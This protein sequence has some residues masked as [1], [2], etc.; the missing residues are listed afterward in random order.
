MSKIIIG[1]IA[2]ILASC[3]STFYYKAKKDKNGNVYY[4]FKTDN[5]I[6]I[7]ANIDGF[8][9]RYED[10]SQAQNVTISSDNES[11]Q[12]MLPPPYKHPTITFTKKNYNDIQIKLNRV[13][14]KQALAL[15][16]LMAVPTVGLSLILDL[17]KPSFYKLDPQFDTLSLDFKYSDSYMLSEYNKTIGIDDTEI[18][19]KYIQSYPY[20]KQIRLVVNHR[21]SILVWNA[22]ENRS[23]QA[24]DEFLGL[25]K[26]NSKFASLAEDERNKLKESRE[27]FEVISRSE[28][29]A[30]FFRFMN[31][32]SESLEFPIAKKLYYQTTV[33]SVCALNQIETYWNYLEGNH[34]TLSTIPAR[35]KDRSEWSLYSIS[36]LSD[37]ILAQVHH[38]YNARL[39]LT[40]GQTEL[41]SLK[42][43]I[44]VKL[45]S[46]C[47]ESG[48]KSTNFKK[49]FRDLLEASSNKLSNEILKEIKL[50]E[51]VD[52]A[53]AKKFHTD[54]YKNLDR[55]N[56]KTYFE[57]FDDK[58]VNLYTKSNKTA[59]IDFDA[60]ATYY[61]LM[62][63]L[64]FDNFKEL[65]RVSSSQMNDLLTKELINARCKNY[66]SQN[67]ITTRYSQRFG[68][69]YTNFEF[70]PYRV[71]YETKKELRLYPGLLRFDKPIDFISTIVDFKTDTLL[72]YYSIK[73]INDSL[74]VVELYDD[75]G[76]KRFKENIKANG[77]IVPNSFIIFDA[78]G[79]DAFKVSIDFLYDMMRIFEQNYVLDIIDEDFKKSLRELL[80]LP[81]FDI[82]SYQSKVIYLSSLEDLLAR[83][84]E[85]MNRRKNT[86]VVTHIKCPGMRSI[87]LEKDPISRSLSTAF[88]G[89]QCIAEAW[90][91]GYDFG[92]D[93]IDADK[94]VANCQNGFITNYSLS[95]EEAKRECEWGFFS[96]TSKLR[97]AFNHGITHRHECSVCANWN[98]T[99]RN[100][101]VCKSC[102]DT[103]MVQC[104]VKHHCSL[105]CGDGNLDMK[106]SQR[107]KDEK[108]AYEQT[109]VLLK[110][111]TD[112]AEE[113]DLIRSFYDK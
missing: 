31:K 99:K 73:P 21:D 16:L 17:S 10:A 58:M 52:I 74:L 54:K 24:L 112:K 45:N 11:F 92:S 70:A 41:V 8:L 1:F 25:V 30:D 6:V 97:V 48:S 40:E 90:G 23:E 34:Q 61:D 28:S 14:R 46:S 39:A 105:C 51:F 93:M 68:K 7:N 43:E 89:L 22:I 12:A 78:K 100:N 76:K 67:D 29:P 104:S 98:D 32:Y 63:E 9:C 106:N 64:G 27:A 26:N 108:L 35:D 37:R 42:S 91:G 55:N 83:N 110:K 81:A 57:L 18:L 71:L 87:S 85:E 59:H 36:V 95:A 19:E 47:I 33:D 80:E 69:L 4:R 113:Y 94:F 49:E 53:D 75:K 15:D 101:Y 44:R 56:Q 107:E 77:I 38:Y 72:S 82:H 3:S 50:L 60:L 2:L 84:T 62:V 86:E 103:R 111:Y 66:Y 88:T 109:S 79:H 20:S 96:A 13:V 102:N 65:R 5:T